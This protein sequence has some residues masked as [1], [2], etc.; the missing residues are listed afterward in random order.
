MST[1]FKSLSK[2]YPYFL[3]AFSKDLPSISVSVL[4][5]GH[6]TEMDIK[7]FT[8]IFMGE[9]GLPNLNKMEDF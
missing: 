7:N 9:S 3:S 8:Y 5:L 1:I 6:L 4:S 2:N